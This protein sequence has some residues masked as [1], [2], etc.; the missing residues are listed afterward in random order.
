[1]IFRTF[2]TKIKKAHK[3]TK[4]K[5]LAIAAEGAK[6]PIAKGEKEYIAINQI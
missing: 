6:S 4:S 5:T 2:Y 1:M 3:P